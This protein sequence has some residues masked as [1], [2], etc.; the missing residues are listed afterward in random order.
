MLQ[1]RERAAPFAPSPRS[2]SRRRVPAARSRLSPTSFQRRWRCFPDFTARPVC[3]RRRP[4]WAYASRGASY[5][6]S[7]PES[8][9]SGSVFV[10]RFTARRRSRAARETTLRRSLR[11]HRAIEPAGRPARL[12]SIFL[13]D[14]AS[15][16]IAG[17]DRNQGFASSSRIYVSRTTS[18]LDGGGSLAACRERGVAER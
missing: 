3:F 13:L 2:C 11:A 16:A 15:G 6:T 18:W 12:A 5:A 17:G 8:Q 1:E 9:Q 4:V 14:G 7:G 10:Q